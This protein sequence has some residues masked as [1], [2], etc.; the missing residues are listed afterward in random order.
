MSRRFIYQIFFFLVLLFV[1]S[2]CKRQQK[3]VI[4]KVTLWRQDKIPY[5]TWVAYENLKYT[6]PDAR[7]IINKSSPDRSKSFGSIFD[8]TYFEP[9][10]IDQKVVYIIISQQVNPDSA[11]LASMLNFVEQGNHVFISAF[12]I[13]SS[14]LDTL[15][16]QTQLADSRYSQNDSLQLSIYHP[17]SH[18]SFRYTYPGLAIDDYFTEMDSSR[19]QVLGRNDDGKP[20]FVRLSFQNGGSVYIHLAP[21]ALTNFFLLHKNNK[22]YYDMVFSYLPININLIKWDDYFRHNREQTGNFSSLG[23]L[24]KHQSFRWAILLSLLV[25]LLLFL[26]E[27]KR[28]Q[29]NIPVIKSLSNSS[30]DFIK[31]VGRL[32]FQRRDNKNLALKMVTHF[33]EYVRSKYNISTS[34]MNEEFI[35]RLSFKSGCS[36]QELKDIVYH[37]KT[38]QDFPSVQDDTLLEINQKFDHF[39]KK[40][41][42]GRSH[43]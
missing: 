32:Y 41:N 13:G 20:N 23:F 34:E 35:Q 22:S 18:N 42:N 19:T 24:M 38:I 16:L 9:P 29:R 25:F 33:N 27:S 40:S 17:L 28:K 26:F 11:E 5:G 3:E 14:F 21:M 31:T 8:N 4:K 12:Y 2:S 30:L 39:F 37:I 10:E 7:I 43:I 36:Q 1:F 6:F 15:H